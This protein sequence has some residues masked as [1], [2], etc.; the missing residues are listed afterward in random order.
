MSLQEKLEASEE[1]TLSKVNT[2]KAQFQEHKAKW[3]DVRFTQAFLF[4]QCVRTCHTLSGICGRNRQPL[5]LHA[6]HHCVPCVFVCVCVCVCVCVKNILK[7]SEKT[8]HTHTHMHV[9]QG[10]KN[11]FGVFRT[12]AHNSCKNI[13]AIASK[14]RVSTSAGVLVLFVFQVLKS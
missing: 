6:A 1:K 9:L 11:S 8:T 13:N 5:A 10:E 2:L 14:Q 4:L 3:E 7:I 12:H